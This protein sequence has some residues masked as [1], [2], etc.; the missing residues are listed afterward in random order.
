MKLAFAV[1][2]GFCLDLL[3]GDPYWLPHS[4][5]WIGRLITFLERWLRSML[6]QTPADERLGGLLLVLLAAGV[7]T[8]CMILLMGLANWLHPAAAFLL[9]VW[10][11]YQ[12]IAA[13]SLR[14]ESM[15]VLKALQQGELEQAR[16]AVGQIVGRD[17][18]QLSP[19]QVAKAAVETVAENTSDG[20][21]APLFYLMLGGAPLGIFYKA[22]NTL[23]SMVGYR[24]VRYRD[25][26]YASA[27]LD[28]LLNW[29]P[30]RISALLMVGAA[31]LL[32]LDWRRAWQVW[33]RDRRKHPSPNSAQTESACAGALGVQLLGGA[34]YGGVWVEKETIGDDLRVVS[35]GDIRLT[36]R[37]MYLTAL[38]AVLLFAL[39]RTVILW[40]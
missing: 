18:D 26:G 3:L 13:K 14:E 33:R 25:F 32:R 2:L 8:A 20:V 4:V 7:P 35:G 6:P 31:A 19:V 38:L 9:E 23:D 29:L 1:A 12:L 24:N 34:F 16:R 11:S 5:R 10:V 39:A 40:R 28:D 17:T 37:L 27:K 22:V 15:K 21:V 30:A 36:N